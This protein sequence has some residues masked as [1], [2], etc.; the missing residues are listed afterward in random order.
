MD[1]DYD[2]LWP[3]LVEQGIITQEQLDEALRRRQTT[4]LDRP[5]GDILVRLRYIEMNSLH[6]WLADQMGI[7]KVQ[8]SNL[9]IPPHIRAMVDYCTAFLYRVV[10]VEERNGVL[11]VATGD[12]TRIG[13]LDQLSHRLRQPRGTGIG[14]PQGCL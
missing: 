5:L 10:P 2:L 7:A 6:E 3:R 11:V 12:P 4:M 13:W 1:A 9:E 14:V 8:L